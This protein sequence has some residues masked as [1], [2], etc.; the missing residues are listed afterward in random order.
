MKKDN[1]E[2]A[3]S[4]LD[5]LTLMGK[6]YQNYLVQTRLK[7]KVYIER[8]LKALA[9]DISGAQILK[10]YES[11]LGKFAVNLN[12]NNKNYYRVLKQLLDKAL[13]DGKKNMSAQLVETVAKTRDG[14]LKASMPVL[15]VLSFNHAPTKANENKEIKLGSGKGLPKLNAYTH[16][17][18]KPN[19]KAGEKTSGYT[20]YGQGAFGQKTSGGVNQ[21]AKFSEKKQMD[22]WHDIMKDYNENK[23]LEPL[24]DE[25]VASNSKVNLDEAKKLYRGSGAENS[26]SKPPKQEKAKQDNKVLNSTLE[27]NQPYIA[28]ILNDAS[29]VVSGLGGAK[30]SGSKATKQEQVKDRGTYYGPEF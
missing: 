29:S 11:L 19:Q 24:K 9:K 4:L 2:I 21:E 25:V 14:Y 30:S 3:K 12:V 6:I 5:R 7:D 16:S 23:P 22:F 10:R 26:G 18:G 8:L 1:D 20:R 28:A 27:K 17:G 13:E 15:E